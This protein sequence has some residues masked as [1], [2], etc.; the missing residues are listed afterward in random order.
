[1]RRPGDGGAAAVEFALVLPLLLMI[2][3]GI[4]NLGQA[5]TAQLV[6]TRAAQDGA[7][8]GALRQQGVAAVVQSAVQSVPGVAQVLVT[9]CPFSGPGDSAVTVTVPFNVTAAGLLGL[10]PVLTLSATSQVPCEP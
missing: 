7:R 6:I 8:L 9:P 4:V 10:G 1:M 2:L 5:L 3:F